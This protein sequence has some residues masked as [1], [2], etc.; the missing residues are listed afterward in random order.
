M[1]TGLDLAEAS[2]LFD[3]YCKMKRLAERTVHSYIAHMLE[4]GLARGTIR[5]RMR[6]IRVFCNFLAR[7]GIVPVSPFAGVEIPRVPERFPEVLS[8]KEINSLL[9]A[10]TGKSFTAIRNAALILTD[11]P[12]TAGNGLCSSVAGCSSRFAAGSRYGD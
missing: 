11:K 12:R 7:E 1:S 2:R 5:I 9:S 4:R 8:S 6:S 3:L 10:S